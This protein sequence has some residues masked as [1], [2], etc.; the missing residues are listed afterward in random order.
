MINH[1]NYRTATTK[2]HGDRDILRPGAA[3]ARR[4]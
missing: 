2:F 3:G 1:I 4:A